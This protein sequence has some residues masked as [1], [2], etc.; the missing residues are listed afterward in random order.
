MADERGWKGWL[1]AD[2]SDNFEM[3]FS[4]V[5]RRVWQCLVCRFF[6]DSQVLAEKE[7]RF[8]STASGSSLLSTRG[9]AENIWKHSIKWSKQLSNSFPTCSK[10][11]SNIN[12][13]GFR[14]VVLRWSPHSSPLDPC[15]Q[16]SCSQVAYSSSS[17]RKVWL[18]TRSGEVRNVLRGFS[19]ANSLFRLDPF[20][21]GRS[22]CGWLGFQPVSISRGKNGRFDSTDSGHNDLK[23]SEDW[24]WIHFESVLGRIP[25][26]PW[27]LRHMQCSV[28][29]R[30]FGG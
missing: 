17:G 6:V 18:G 28:R 13:S 8:V 15:G 9:D 3:V 26:L 12:S 14:R 24:R 5:F 1:G 22:G 21:D 25:D 10:T 11:C 4:D 16:A 27:C 7:R 23:I 29:Q 2:F 19:I 30:N 20:S